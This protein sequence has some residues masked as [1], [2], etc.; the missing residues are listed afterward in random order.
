MHIYTIAIKYKTGDS[1]STR[2]EKTTLDYDWTNPEIVKENMIRI[3]EHYEW[4]RGINES[5]HDEKPP[6]PDFMKELTKESK[7]YEEY[8]L[9][10]KKDDGSIFQISVK[11]T[12]Y[13]ERLISIEIQFKNFKIEF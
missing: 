4:V 1:F 2:E 5:W 12:G 13:F 11:W 6:K 10:L 3:K 7:A 9:P 8:C